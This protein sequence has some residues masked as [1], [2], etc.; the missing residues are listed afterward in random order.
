[1]Q[2]TQDVAAVAF[3][4]GRETVGES[5]GRAKDKLRHTAAVEE[6]TWHQALTTLDMLCMSM[7]QRGRAHGSVS[8]LS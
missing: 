1:M 4:Y 2:T 8:L 5:G 3:E 6:T 7:A